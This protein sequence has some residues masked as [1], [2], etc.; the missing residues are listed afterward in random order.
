MSDSRGSSGGT[1]PAPPNPP[2][3]VFNTARRRGGQP[4]AGDGVKEGDDTRPLSQ[5]ETAA[6]IAQFH[7]F[8][9]KKLKV[10]LKRVLDQRDR[11]YQKTAD[12]VELKRNIEA[13]QASQQSRLTT[14]VNIGC[15]FFVEAIVPDVSLL[16]VDIG[17]GFHIELTLNEAV[18]FI[19]D[20]EQHLEG[21]AKA[22]S[23]R[24]AVI[25]SHIKLVYEG[26][27]EL[28]KLQPQ[29]TSKKSASFYG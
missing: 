6:K 12:Y 1:R 26:I 23:K 13:V 29:P 28:M 2:V 19:A 7:A 20:K 5:E 8:I 27:A 10:D 25:S 17:L 3:P 9:D 11:I 21:L 14:R 22:L 24:A 15:D 16:V 4:G 18:H